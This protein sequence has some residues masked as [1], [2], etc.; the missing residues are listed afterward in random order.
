IAVEGARAREVL[1]Q[2]AEA[3]GEADRRKDEFLAMLAHELRN[4]LVPI[5]NAV[6]LLRLR[7]PADADTVRARELIERQVGHLVRL[8]DDLLAVSRITRGTLPRRKLPL[9]LAT[10]VSAALEGGEPLMQQRRHTLEVALP[11]EPVWVVGDLTRL[12]QVLLNLLA[13]SAKYT[14]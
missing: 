10:V 11:R 3:L 6:E 14:D 7:G 4:P 5:R 12:A 1:V 2:R 13:N 9:D 8:V